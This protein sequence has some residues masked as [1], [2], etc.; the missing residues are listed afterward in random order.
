MYKVSLWVSATDPNSPQQ[1]YKKQ[2]YDGL[3]A[4]Q[5]DKK[6]MSKQQINDV[7]EKK[8]IKSLSAQNP[9]LKLDFKITAIERVSDFFFIDGQKD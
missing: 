4:P 9:T 2:A 1:K 8:L 3:V 7:I 6:Q 5:A